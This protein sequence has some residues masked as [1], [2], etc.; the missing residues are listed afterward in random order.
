V[1]ILNKNQNARREKI[2]Q[3]RVA[4]YRK[5][6]GHTVIPLLE[7]AIGMPINH[8]RVLSVGTGGGED[9]EVLDH[10]GADSV[11]VDIDKQNAPFW[12]SKG[13]ECILADG[14][15]LPFKERS[16]DC[17]IA[18][19]I[20]EHVGQ[21]KKGMMR[22]LERKE[23]AK[24]LMRICGKGGGVFLSTPNKKFPID[25]A[26]TGMDRDIVGGLRVGGLRFHSPWE[27]FTVSFEELRE[28]FN[29]KEGGTSIFL[30]SPLGYVN[31][32]WEFFMK[33][34]LIKYIVFPIGRLWVKLLNK[35]SCLRVSF[36]NP[37]LIL[38]AKVI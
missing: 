23:F 2:R 27:S 10:L 22:R 32:D 34:A 6:I 12:L 25:I 24:E 31:W 38:I 7:R 15:H 5:K 36:L 37:H 1:S 18:I 33:H 13:L 19:E 8:C 11:G 26:H 3:I 16:F 28:L 21:E 9:V 14:R 29:E 35:F 4:W 30:V 20:I 17:V